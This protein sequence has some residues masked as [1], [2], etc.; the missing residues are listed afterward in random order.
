MR[1]VQRRRLV[2][3]AAALLTVPRSAW[4]QS[5]TVR[6]GVLSPRRESVILRPVL[7]R[8][9]EL[10]YVEG[11]NLR[12]EYR[13]ADGVVDRFP[14]LARELLE[15]KCDLI[16][17]AGSMHAARALRDATESVPII[18]VA[19]DYDPVNAG[20]VTNLRRPGRNITGVALS[21]PEVVGK[22]VEILHEVLPRAKRFLVFSDP[23][24]SEQLE[25]MRQMAKRLQVELVVHTFESR[26]YAFDAAFEQGEKE[27]V[28]AL[29]LPTSPVFF[30]RRAAIYELA[31]K[32]RLALVVGS[33]PW[34][35][36]SGWLLRIGDKTYVRAGDIAGSILKGKKPGEIPI[37]QPSDFEFT[38]NLQ[39][40]KALG[41]KVPQSVLVRATRVME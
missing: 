15:A 37:E 25:T 12:L 26:P 17:A 4:T 13:S 31:L 1:L 20:I 5:R 10:G 21:T 2:F 9:G 27:G 34:T 36:G 30:D 16:F 28:A 40:A 14:G 11:R 33:S 29:L 8:L 39:T 38:V 6:I 18:I 3:A 19:I 7:A 32:R 41:I 23:Y 24:S 35:N 22:R